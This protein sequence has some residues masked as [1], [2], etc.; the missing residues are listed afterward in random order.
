MMR[1][2]VLAI[3]FLILAGI[4]NGQ[5]DTDKFNYE[6]GEMVTISL[7]TINGSDKTISI[8]TSSKLYGYNGPMYSELTFLPEEEGKHIIELKKSFGEII[9]QKEFWVG[10][11]PEGVVV[12][13]PTPIIKPEVNESN[14]VNETIETNETANFNESINENESVQVNG[15]KIFSRDKF[16]VGEV[17]EIKLKDIDYTRIELPFKDKIYTFLGD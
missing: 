11:L 3:L 14:D 1:K 13:E 7:G 17:I 10:I 12:E 8:K 2:I 16:Y 6:P 5:L 4:V 15:T 9:G